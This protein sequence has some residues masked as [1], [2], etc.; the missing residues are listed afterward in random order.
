MFFR[1]QCLSSYL[2]IA[3]TALQTMYYVLCRHSTMYY[4]SEKESEDP[5]PCKKLQVSGKVIIFT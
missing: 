1:D 5:K 4:D 3:M 2:L